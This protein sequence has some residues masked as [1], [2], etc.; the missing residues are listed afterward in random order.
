M[1]V[2]PFSHVA[3]RTPLLTEGLKM[4]EPGETGAD[5]AT[6][7]SQELESNA[8]DDEKG[9]DLEVCITSEKESGCVKSSSTSSHDTDEGQ[10]QQKTDAE[11]KKDKYG[12]PR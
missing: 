10:T 1:Q 4:P 5:L 11:L 2:S 3:S 9:A 8:A 6:S 7:G 12:G